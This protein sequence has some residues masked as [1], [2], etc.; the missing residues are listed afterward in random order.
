MR[1]ICIVCFFIVA[2]VLNSCS[3]L[4]K[5]EYVSSDDYYSIQ[6]RS[7]NIP[8]TIIFDFNGLFC[9]TLVENKSGIIHKYQQFYLIQ[10]LDYKKVL[11]LY[12]FIKNNSILHNDTVFKNNSIVNRDFESEA[13][14]NENYISFLILMPPVPYEGKSKI[15]WEG[16]K[17][18]TLTKLLELVNDL[19]P[20][21]DRR[22]FCIEPLKE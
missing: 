15:I 4:K 20:I 3:F 12:F 5:K 7:N 22:V 16:G 21:V 9:E 6:I 18:R 10:T 13:N 11:E 1:K 2:S 14:F 19:I 8:R 17:N